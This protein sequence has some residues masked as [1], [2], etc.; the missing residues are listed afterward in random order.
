M[1]HHDSLTDLPNRTLLQERLEE[2]LH[3][4]RRGEQLAV[5]YLDLDHFK[6]VNDTLGH[7]VGDALL[8]QVAERLRE[9]VR[10]TDTVARLGGDEFA[11]IQSHLDKPSEAAILAT[12]IRDA[13]RHPYELDEHHVPTDVSIGISI[14]PND[15]IE[16]EQLL[17]NADMA[18]YRSKADG[19]GTF[20]FF[21]PEMDESIKARRSL[22][23]D[24]R[25]ALAKSEFELYYQP[26]VNLESNNISCARRYFVG[27]I[28]HGE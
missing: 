2:A 20:R 15:G 18:L 7:G 25:K 11:I 19:R 23:L 17:R 26:L 21:E 16:S 8:K 10:E 24:L 3:H 28:P 13:L 12:R 27:I 4:A 9:C 1:A 22:E 6:S 14:A 5:L